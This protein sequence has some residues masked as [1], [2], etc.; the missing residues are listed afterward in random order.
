MLAYIYKSL[1]IHWLLSVVRPTKH[2]F[3]GSIPLPLIHFQHLALI[4][5]SFWGVTPPSS[6]TFL[7]K[8]EGVNPPLMFIH[9]QKCMIH[10]P[11]SWTSWGRGCWHNDTAWCQKQD[12]WWWQLHFQWR[13]AR[14]RAH[15]SGRARRWWPRE[16]HDEENGSIFQESWHIWYHLRYYVYGSCRTIDFFHVESW[17]PWVPCQWISLSAIPRWGFRTGARRARD[18]LFLPPVRELE[19]MW[20]IATTCW[21]IGVDRVCRY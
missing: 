4:H 15:E 20:A 16:F 3:S 17:I 13:C 14:W 21:L 11:Y 12:I 19:F 9:Y 18:A 5:A 8:S 1:C 6:H 7:A 10:P 2:T